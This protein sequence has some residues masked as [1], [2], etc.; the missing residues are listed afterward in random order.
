IDAFQHWIYTHPD[1]TREERTAQWNDLE[2][3][4]GSDVSWDGL[5]KY[6]DTGWQRQLHL[7]EVPFYYIE[8]GIAQLGALQLW[9]IARQDEAKAIEQYRAALTLGGSRPLPEL[10][11]AAGLRFDFSPATMKSLMDD[12]ASELKRLPV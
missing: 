3:R 1:H 5:E 7:F 12:V 8:Y 4:F 2:R 9:Q 6:R 11:E 10:F